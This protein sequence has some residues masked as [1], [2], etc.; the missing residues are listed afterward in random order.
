MRSIRDMGNV[1]EFMISKAI[2]I[3]NAFPNVFSYQDI[4]NMDYDSMIKLY[5]AA[6]E[7]IKWRQTH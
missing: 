6:Q 4:V 2:G 1:E 7:A 3:S 5:A